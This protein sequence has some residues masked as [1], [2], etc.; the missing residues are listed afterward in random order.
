[1][2][3]SNICVG[4]VVVID[5]CNPIRFPGRYEAVVVVRPSGNL[6]IK[7]RPLRGFRRWARWVE[8]YQ[9]DGVVQTKELYELEKMAQRVLE[10]K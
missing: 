10:F 4:D 5:S 3:I 1:L 7:V 8:W 9:V 2:D 6:T